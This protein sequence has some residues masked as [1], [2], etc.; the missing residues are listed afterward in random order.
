MNIDI[1]K[2]DDFYFPPWNFEI[3]LA[4]FQNKAHKEKQTNKL[5]SGYDWR[6]SWR[7]SG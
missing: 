2:Q 6:Q 7:V 3:N 5:I 4:Y 1:P